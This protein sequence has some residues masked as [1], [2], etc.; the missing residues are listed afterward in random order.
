[1]SYIVK[2]L[3]ADCVEFLPVIIPPLMILLRTN[4]L[5]LIVD[6]YQCVNAIIV[7]VPR[8]INKFSD[9]IFETINEVMFT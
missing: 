4:D 8:D 7:S 9:L 2:H 5:A 3:G 6:L 1:M